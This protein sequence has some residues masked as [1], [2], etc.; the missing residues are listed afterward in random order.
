MKKCSTAPIIKE[1]Q[2]KTH[3]DTP[4]RM[5]KI[6]RPTITSASRDVKQ[7]EFSNAAIRN[8]KL[9]TQFGKV[10][11]FLTKLD[12][13]SPPDPTTPL[14]GIYPR[15]MKTRPHKNLNSNVH[16][17]PNVLK[18]RSSA[19]EWTNCG[20]H[21]SSDQRNKLPM[22]ATTQVS[23]KS[24][25]LAERDRP[26]KTTNLATLFLW[27]PRKHNS[28]VTESRPV[29]AR[30]KEE[31]REFGADDITMVWVTTQKCTLVKKSINCALELGEFYM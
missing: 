30:G 6:K 22:H 12:R 13:H 14:L 2:I 5:A 20:R 1:I 24:T 8:T 9:N 10:W 4:T 16:F 15:E 21:P 19:G 18:L 28:T 27:N 3:N 29:V 17:I 11:K 26:Q 25:L 7:L 23:L 31:G